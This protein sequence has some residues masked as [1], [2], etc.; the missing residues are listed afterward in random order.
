MLLGLPRDAG[1]LS[2]CIETLAPVIRHAV[3][4]AA[5]DPRDCG[6]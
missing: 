6:R 3:E 5:G 2:A 4:K 1:W